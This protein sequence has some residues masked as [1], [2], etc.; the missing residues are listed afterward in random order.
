MMAYRA[1]SI[2][3]LAVAAVAVSVSGASAGG[4]RVRAACENDYY[5]F[6]SQYDPDS[7]QVSRCFESNRKN[8]SR[9]C[10]RALVDAGEVPAKYLKK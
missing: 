4:K 3:A 10:I 5:S 6:C 7:N 2:A 1:L 8:L 9:G